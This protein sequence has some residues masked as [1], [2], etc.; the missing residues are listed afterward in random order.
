[1]T[2]D[3]DIPKVEELA[4]RVDNEFGLINGENMPNHTAAMQGRGKFVMQTVN[5]RAT[6]YRTKQ[7]SYRYIAHLLKL[8]D[9]LPDEDGEHTLAEIQAA[10][11]LHLSK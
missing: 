3:S 6:I 7:Q 1:M 5:S 2:S 11:E 8:S 4:V 9:T 10:L